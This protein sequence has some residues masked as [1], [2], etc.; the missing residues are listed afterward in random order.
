MIVI[1]VLS[2]AVRQNYVPPM[3]FCQ[4]DLIERKC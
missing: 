4:K 1:R 2:H 3:D